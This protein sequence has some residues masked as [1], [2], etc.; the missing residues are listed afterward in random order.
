MIS[1]LSQPIKST[2]E[3]YKENVGLIAQVAQQKQSKY[4]NI[5]STI[6]QKQNQLLNLDLSYAPD[7]IVKEKDNLL[8]EADNQLNKLA[9]SDLT[10]PDNISKVEN[11]F[12]PITS[13]QDVML[14][15]GFTKQVN[16][17]KTYYEEMKKEGKGDY[18][19]TNEAY[20][21]TQASKA[22]QMT[23]EQFKNSYNSLDISP[24]KYRNRAKE[25][26]EALSKYVKD[27]GFTVE[28][29]VSAPDGGYIVTKEQGKIPISSLKAVLPN[30]AGFVAQ[31][32]V[33]AW[34]SL[35]NTTQDEILSEQLGYVKND[36]Q[37][38]EKINKS[39]IKENEDIT[40]AISK[41]KTGNTSNLSLLFPELN[42]IDLD[43][44]ENKQKAIDFLNSKI[45]NN[46]K[47]YESNTSNLVENNKYITEMIGKYGIIIGGDG[48]TSI[49]SDPLPE[50]QLLNLKTQYI[51]QRDANIFTQAYAK[52][53]NVIKIES[54]PNYRQA[55]QIQA[56]IA[57]ETQK[58]NNDVKL[59]QLDAELKLI[60]DGANNG[61]G[62]NNPNEIT[63][64]IAGE[65]IDE[66]TKEEK[67]TKY[68]N[69]LTTNLLNEVGNLDRNSSGEG[70]TLFKQEL[71]RLAPVGTSS[72]NELSPEE[73]SKLTKQLSSE[74]KEVNDNL[75][76]WDKNP[77]SIVP[78]RKIT[79]EEYFKEKEKTINYINE[80][81]LKI[82]TAQAAFDLKKSVKNTVR[83]K[84]LA[85]LK[86]IETKFVM[87]QY[88]L[89][90][91]FLQENN[92]QAIP[93]EYKLKINPIYINSDGIDK[94]DVLRI[95]Q[96]NGFKNI[97]PFT[98]DKFYNKIR[99]FLIVN[100]DASKITTSINDQVD[101][102]LKKYTTSSM[103]I[104]LTL[105]GESTEK[106]PHAALKKSTIGYIKGINQGLVNTDIQI[107]NFQPTSNGW[108]VSYSVQT[109]EKNP[110]GTAKV[111]VQKPVILSKDFVTQNQAYLKGFQSNELLNIMIAQKK[112][113]ESNNEN[114]LNNKVITSPYIQLNGKTYKLAILSGDADGT[115]RI[116]SPNK[117]G[118][119]ITDDL[120]EPMSFKQAWEF[121]NTPFKSKQTQSSIESIANK[122][123]IQ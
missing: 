118:I 27:M 24:I 73:Q 40:G 61:S 105:Q 121:I 29:L 31:A 46:K 41:L 70:S 23:K 20:T 49:G 123:L 25:Y 39:I 11:I 32:K 107:N 54:D 42:G 16:D 90:K 75:T 65:A 122:Y 113:H 114:S 22:K 48:F 36:I 115:I 82:A 28:N 84:E 35:G 56:D 2:V 21:L 104:P 5:L 34:A 3:P 92:L 10:I 76:N 37:S 98:I 9:S 14:G 4:D 57:K 77:N 117:K 74:I 51:L 26:N 106:D 72:I 67:G 100:G 68:Y 97:T 87:S 111:I 44:P 83:T 108:I 86:P 58:Y 50:N 17:S 45:E 89:E 79:Y 81:N 64:L 120:S 78:G 85:N 1:Y 71:L 30:D 12:T 109:N 101:K 93:L 88:E 96:E 91:S 52:E 13:N 55:V 62:S 66:P 94:K 63:P 60:T 116:G 119:I 59:K 110:D 53:K 69:D 95:M 38:I 47:A 103:S 80:R 102:E 7:D 112:F 19:P 6:F 8:K 43:I 33:D 15:L 18:D 99:S